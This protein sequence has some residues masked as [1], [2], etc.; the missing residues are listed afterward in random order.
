MQMLFEGPTTLPGYSKIRLEDYTF[1]PGSGFPEDAMANAMFCHIV[2]GEIQ[3]VLDGK[4]F[5][6][7]QNDVFTCNVGTREKDTNTSDKVAVMR[8]LNLLTT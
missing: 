6:A 4:E 7:K 3:V 1:Q 2:E 8:I 5:T